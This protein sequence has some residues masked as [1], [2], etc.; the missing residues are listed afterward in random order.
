MLTYADSDG[1]VSQM[2]RRSGLHFIVPVAEGDLVLGGQMEPMP[3]PP[4]NEQ[5]EFRFVPSHAYVQ[6]H[7]GERVTVWQRKP[8]G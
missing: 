2:L 6:R 1:S 4:S 8:A 3:A 5:R 7:S